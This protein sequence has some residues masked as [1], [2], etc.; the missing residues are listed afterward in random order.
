MHVFH[1]NSGASIKRAISWFLLYQNPLSNQSLLH[2]AFP[3]PTAH[4]NSHVSAISIHV[5]LTRKQL[6]VSCFIEIP[7]DTR[8]MTM[9]FT[10]N[11][12]HLPPISITTCLPIKL[13]CFYQE[14]TFLVTSISGTLQPSVSPPNSTPPHPSASLWLLHILIHVCHLSLGLSTKR[15]FPFSALSRPPL[16]LQYYCK[17]HLHSDPP[18]LNT[19]NDYHLSAISIQY[20]PPV[21]HPSWLPL[22]F[23]LNSGVSIKKETSWFLLHQDNLTHQ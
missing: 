23:Y 17:S 19:L 16:R 15:D 20:F 10:P 22:V 5:R 4:L 1:L 7:P 12:S 18:S 11:A 6:P 3:S 13:R 2:R 9:I 14:R 8:N 21:H